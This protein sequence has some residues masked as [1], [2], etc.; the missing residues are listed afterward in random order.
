MTP[1][2]IEI[3]IHHHVCPERHPRFDA[4]AVQETIRFFVRAKI[5]EETDNSYTTTERGEALVELLCKTELPQQAWVD[6][7]GSVILRAK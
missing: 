4:P 5:F 6:K 3:L 7:D 1:S 2:D